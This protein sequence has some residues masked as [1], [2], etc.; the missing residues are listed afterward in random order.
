MIV[1][2]PYKLDPQNGLELRYAIRS[3]YQH[4]LRMTGVILIG[5]KPDW[6]KGEYINYHNATD[7]RRKEQNMI[8]KVALMEGDFLYTN[9]DFYLLKTVSELP[10]YY[11]LENKSTSSVYKQM[12]RNMPEGWKDFDVHTP[13]MMNGEKFRESIQPGLPIKSMYAN[14]HNLTGVLYEDLKFRQ[15]NN[16]KSIMQR[17]EGRTIFS[18]HNS[19]MNN[20]MLKVLEEL[21]PKPSIYER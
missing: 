8:E 10:N 16:Y 18:T 4:F 13:M 7:H 15:A 2:I 5:D 19:C 17:L 6:Y 20:D 1:A 14:Y 21:Y 3:M 9:D 12:Y 11:Q